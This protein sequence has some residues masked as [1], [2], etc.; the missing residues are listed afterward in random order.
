MEDCVVGVS[1]IRL[2]LSVRRTGL[3]CLKITEVVVI[4][5]GFL[6]MVRPELATIE[7]QRLALI[8]LVDHKVKTKRKS[9]LVIRA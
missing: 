9:V 5:T 2:L 4:F 1:V 7:T 3:A 8:A 6:C